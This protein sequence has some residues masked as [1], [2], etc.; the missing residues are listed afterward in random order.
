MSRKKDT[1]KVHK[2]FVIE[3]PEGADYVTI[4]GPGCDIRVSSA[5]SPMKWSIGEPGTYTKR[6]MTDAGVEVSTEQFEVE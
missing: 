3:V 1:L 2:N 5:F 4:T 6:A